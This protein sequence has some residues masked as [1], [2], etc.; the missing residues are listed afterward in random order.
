MDRIDLISYSL[1]CEGEYGKIA[2]AM[3]ASIEIPA[4]IRMKALQCNNVI[5]MFDKEYPKELLELAW[6]PFVLFYKGDIS[7]LDKTHTR[8]AIVGSRMATDYSL[9]ATKWLCTQNQDK[10]IV[11]GLAKGIDACAHENATKTIAVLGCGIDYIYPLCNKCL[12]DEIENNG[13]LLSEYP[14]TT[15]PLGYH[16][17][18]RNRIVAALSTCVY[19]AECKHHSGTM[20][21]INEALTLQK[22][23]KVLP[24][25]VFNAK[26][27]D[28]YNNQLIN[29][30]AMIWDL[31]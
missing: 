8:I 28:V 3:K 17:P 13:L 9:S 16:F 26:Y 1:M 15:K 4:D 21:T 12:F 27:N 23:V 18:Y 11:S 19:V 2:E 22:D 29:E 10:V 5:T 30:G 14:G 7:L 31:K 20:T 6:P 24:F 25:D